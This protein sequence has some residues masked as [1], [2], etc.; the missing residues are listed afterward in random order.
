MG[1]GGVGL[2]P[3]WR[4]SEKTPARTATAPSPINAQPHHGRPLPE[5]DA[6]VAVAGVTVTLVLLRV[7]VLLVVAGG[8]AAVSV[9]VT[10]VVRGGWV[11]VAVAVLVVVAFVVE[12]V[13][14]VS[15]DAAPPDSA[16]IARPAINAARA[17]WGRQ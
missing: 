4:P 8:A 9:V 3:P 15:A 6:V 5:S 2:R 7:V 12:S 13:D 16:P 10:V 14:V 11:V 17:D 1:P